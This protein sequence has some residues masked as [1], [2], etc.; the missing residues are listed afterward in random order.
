M[1]VKDVALL[2]KNRE[3]NDNDLRSLRRT[4]G[5]L[6]QEK[7][8]SRLPYFDFV[9]EGVGYVYGL[10][11][12][13]VRGYGGKAFDEHSARTL[14]HE[15]GI[16]LFHVSLKQ[17]TRQRGFTLYWRQTHLK[18]S[19]IHPDALFALT[20]PSKPAGRNTHYFF[21]EIERSKIGNY[22]EGE[23]SI[24]R[25][26]AKYYDLFDTADCEAAWGFRHFRVAIVL[27]TEE[28][29]HNLCRSLQA[30]YRHQMFWLTT[31]SLCKQNIGGRIF[32][33]PSDHEPQSRGFDAL[34]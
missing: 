23:P 5:L 22:R 12:K 4:L 24:S 11:N 7:L 33:T 19:V 20:D 18:R 21:L 13:G 15:L 29:R 2:L 10:S 16:T 17:F 3:P 8:A 6:W 28:R 31:E 32:V 27:H 9:T 26:I 34:L 14:D 25:K 1:R 30:P